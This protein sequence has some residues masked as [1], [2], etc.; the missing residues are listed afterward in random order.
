MLKP[1]GTEAVFELHNISTID[2]GNY[3]CT[4]MEQE[5][6]FSGSAPS[7]LLELHVK[8]ELNMAGRVEGSM[9]S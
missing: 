8:G 1:S 5:A 2:S 9:W 3:S 7:E 4:Y 6:P